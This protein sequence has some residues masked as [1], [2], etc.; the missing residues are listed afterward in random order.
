M[1]LRVPA[2]FSALVMPRIAPQAKSSKTQQEL[3]PDQRQHGG[4]PT[5]SVYGTTRSDRVRLR[6]IVGE[7]IGDQFRCSWYATDPFDSEAGDSLLGTALA[8]TIPETFTSGGR[9]YEHRSGMVYGR[10]T[11]DGVTL[12]VVA[13]REGHADPSLRPE[14]APSQS[15]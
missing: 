12:R 3:C 11:A 9:T 13:G 7:S 2:S 6:A 4:R 10:C 5:P 1:K 15:Q 8:V 14:L